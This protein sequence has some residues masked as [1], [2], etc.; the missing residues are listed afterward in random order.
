MTSA[1]LLSRV[2]G[3]VSRELCGE[4]GHVLPVPLI[5]ACVRDTLVA[6][7]R[8]ISSQALPEMAAALAKVRL[9]GIADPRSHPGA[10]ITTTQGDCSRTR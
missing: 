5:T 1:T 6:L 3:R 9:A 7:N 8:S 10:A 2:A 4:F